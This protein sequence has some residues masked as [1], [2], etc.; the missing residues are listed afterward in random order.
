MS[1]QSKAREGQRQGALSGHLV[2]SSRA[3]AALRARR[4]GQDQSTFRIIFAICS[5]KGSDVR[6]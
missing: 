4:G 3:L 2:V 1:V 6:Y 5:G